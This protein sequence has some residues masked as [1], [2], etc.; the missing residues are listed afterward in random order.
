MPPPQA[1]SPGC[2]NIPAWG[3]N[4]AWVG[5]PAA[6]ARCAEWIKGQPQAEGA[7]LLRGVE[8]AVIEP[9]GSMMQRVALE[10]T[11]SESDGQ[12]EIFLYHRQR[13]SPT[14]PSAAAAHPGRPSGGSE[15]LIE[16]AAVP[17]GPVLAP[18]R[19]IGARRTLR[20]LL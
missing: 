13:H 1:V 14:T 12:L 5:L 3:K 9:S 16:S 2:P 10:A 15:Q 7:R 8:R 19:R 17:V 6:A 4:R 18:Q 11:R 20:R